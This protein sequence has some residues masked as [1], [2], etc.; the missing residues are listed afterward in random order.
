MAL[1]PVAAISSL[2][3]YQLDLE[4]SAWHKWGNEVGVAVLVAGS[5]RLESLRTARRHFCGM[6]EE[7]RKSM[8][9]TVYVVL[10]GNSPVPF[11]AAHTMLCFY[12]LYL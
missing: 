8:A 10:I 11:Q 3:S 1:S 6:C 9:W 5:L 12:V 4:V 7:L 2:L